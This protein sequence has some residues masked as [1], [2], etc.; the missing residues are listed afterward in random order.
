MNIFVSNLSFAIGD[1]ELRDIFAPFGEVR[2]AKIVMDRM[3]GRSRGFGF[4]EM[5]DDEAATKAI[6]E[7]NQRPIDNRPINVVE[8]R[9]KEKQV[10]DFSPFRKSGR[11]KNRW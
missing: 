3:T 11:N 6:A 2:D 7:L 1:Q 9:P 10:R 8:A 5:T 4:V